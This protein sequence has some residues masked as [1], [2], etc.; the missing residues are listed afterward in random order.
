MS[1][2][3]TSF[4]A[5]VNQYRTRIYR[6]AC[7][8]LDNPHDAEDITQQV[9]MEAWRGGSQFK[10]RSDPFTWLYTILRRACARH[11]RRHWWRIFGQQTE[12]YETLLAQSPAITPAPCEESSLADD[13]RTVRLILRE[14]STALREVLILRYVEFYTVSEISHLLKIPEGTVKSRIH[15][16]L[17]VAAHHW[18]KEEKP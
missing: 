10:G 9:F 4:E 12:S 1:M 5:W 7:L 8:L 13:I 6:A 17:K 18:P 15:Y 16:A 3:T 14:L 11:R 2:D